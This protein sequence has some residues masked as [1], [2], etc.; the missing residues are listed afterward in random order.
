WSGDQTGGV[1]EY[2]RFHIPTYIGSGLSG[3]PNICSDM[4]GIFGGKNPLVNV[5][6]FQ[7]KTFTPMELNMDGWGA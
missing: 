4:D 3:Q 7:W 1:W 2:I 6:D 5:R